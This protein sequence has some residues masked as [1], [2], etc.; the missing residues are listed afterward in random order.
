MEAG[1]TMK[2]GASL[3]FGGERGGE[4]TEDTERGRIRKEVIE[5]L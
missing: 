2:G 5:G 4:S 3:S 1:P